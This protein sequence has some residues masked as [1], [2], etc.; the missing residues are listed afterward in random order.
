MISRQYVRLAFMAKRLRRYKTKQV[1]TLSTIKAERTTKPSSVQNTGN[2]VYINPS[3]YVA[4]EDASP[5]AFMSGDRALTYGPVFACLRIIADPISSMPIKHFAVEDDGKKINLN[6]DLVYLLD[7][8]PNPE[9]SAFDFKKMMIVQS[10]LWGDSYAEIERDRAGRVLALWPL[11]SER[12]TPRRTVDGRN[13]LYY[14]YLNE[15]GGTSYLDPM[16]LFHLKGGVSLDG[17]TSLGPLQL[18]AKSMNLG[19][20]AEQFGLS[21]YMNGATPGGV[22]EINTV[23]L[24]NE[25]K[26][27]MKEEFNKNHRGPGRAHRVMLLDNGMTFKPLAI[28][29]ETAQFLESRQ[30]QVTEI[31]RWFG[32][33][34]HKLLV[35]DKGGA[36]ANIEQKNIEFVVDTLMPKVA[37]FEAEVRIKLIGRNQRTRQFIRFDTTT[38]SRGDMKSRYDA[39]SSGINSGH[40]TR[41]EVRI[42]EDR[43]ALEYLDE[44]VI[45]VN[46]TTAQRL[47]EGTMDLGKSPVPDTEGEPEDSTDSEDSTEMENMKEDMQDMKRTMVSMMDRLELLLRNQTGN[48]NPVNLTLQQ[49]EQVIQV[50]PSFN[51]TSGQP[52]INVA[53]KQQELPQITIENQ[54]DSPVINVEQPRIDIP[55]PIVQNTYN[56]EPVVHTTVDGAV[57]D[58]RS[59]V[60]VQVPERELKIEVMNEAAQISNQI[61]VT[62]PDVTVMNEIQVPEQPTPEVT[63]V[64]EIKVPEQPTPL[65]N[66]RNDVHVAPSP[67]PDVFLSVDTSDKE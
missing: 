29:L 22:I 18:A 49:P 12:V 52:H 33:P 41:N 3:A 19:L 9:M 28:P 23:K 31:A 61:D 37:Q 53:I 48:Q 13:S 27:A 55:A 40:L 38:L 36:A 57:V 16:D 4:G 21:F 11:D 60:D 34:A 66:V 17:I 50:Q 25:A 67:A 64:N 15:Q 5:F 59:Y 51:L 10:Q 7:I 42:A 44:P 8:Q 20:A 14:E 63:L 45:Q 35:D 62:T 30:F 43:N 26:A 1:T 58:A 32:V 54:V 2:V 6:S 46:M 24:S 39:Y 56:F 65:V 47:A